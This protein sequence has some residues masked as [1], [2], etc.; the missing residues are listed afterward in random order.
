MRG[1]CEINSLV[2]ALSLG[3]CFGTAPGQAGK[4]GALLVRNCERPE[5]KIDF[6]ESDDLGLRPLERSTPRENRTKEII[7]K[8]GTTYKAF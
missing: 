6:A 2:M 5:T 4:R 7:K 3:L 8:P 1:P